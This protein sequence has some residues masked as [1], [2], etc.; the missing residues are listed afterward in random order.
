MFIS[1]KNRI[2]RFSVVQSVACVPVFTSSLTEKVGK[3]E[4]RWT[5]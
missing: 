4:C 2:P 1:K 5:N 3:V